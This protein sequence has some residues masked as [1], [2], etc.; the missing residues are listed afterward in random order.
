MKRLQISKKLV[1]EKFYAHKI[2]T[3]IFSK[4]VLTEKRKQN[5]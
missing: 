1:Y 3:A 2:A 5:M 4:I